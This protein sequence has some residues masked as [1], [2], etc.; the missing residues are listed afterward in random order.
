MENKIN[1]KQER[2][3]RNKKMKTTKESKGIER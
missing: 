1:E 3:N 2:S